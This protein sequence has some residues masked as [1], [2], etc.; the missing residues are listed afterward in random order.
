MPQTLSVKQSKFEESQGQPCQEPKVKKKLVGVSFV[1]WNEL[2]IVS[3]ETHK[4]LKGIVWATNEWD[5]E[6]T[7][8]KESSLDPQISM[9]RR[10]AKKITQL[11]TLVIS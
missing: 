3:Q 10:Q 1:K 4:T 11:Q 5:R 8:C 6:S 9:G 2:Q 7:Q